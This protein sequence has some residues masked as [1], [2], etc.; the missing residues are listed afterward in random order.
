M[1]LR[2]ARLAAGGTV[3]AIPVT[4]LFLLVQKRLVGGLTAGAVKA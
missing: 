3:V 2:A 4:I 1:I